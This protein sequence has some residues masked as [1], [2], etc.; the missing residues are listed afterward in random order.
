MLVGEDQRAGFRLLACALMEGRT[1]EI[2]IAGS[3]PSK[4]SETGPPIPKA[5]IR[6]H[7]LVSARRPLASPSRLWALPESSRSFSE[8]AKSLQPGREG[9][10]ER[11]SGSP[12]PSRDVH[13]RTFAARRRAA[14]ERTGSFRAGSAQTRDGRSSTNGQIALDA[15]PSLNG[16]TTQETPPE[17][18]KEGMHDGKAPQ[19]G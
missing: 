8:T 17:D 18:L 10:E 7:R 14:G 6:R 16:A 19:R 9:R 12:L 1:F 15:T 4:S 13:N 5:V 11:F 2:D 3:D